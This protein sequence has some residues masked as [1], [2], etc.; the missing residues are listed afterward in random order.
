MLY[1]ITVGIFTFSKTWI[2]KRNADTP[3][4]VIWPINISIRITSTVYHMRREFYLM[5]I[6]K[7]SIFHLRLFKILCG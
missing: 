4:W 1:N 3:V 6:L 7:Y 2:N 5:K